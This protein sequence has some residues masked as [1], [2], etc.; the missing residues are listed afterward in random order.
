MEWLSARKA[1]ARLEIARPTLNRIAA[2]AGIRRRQLPGETSP[3]FSAE[4]VERVARES[5]IGAGGPAKV[6]S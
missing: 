1:A 2:V 4:D 3:R 6:A 5:V